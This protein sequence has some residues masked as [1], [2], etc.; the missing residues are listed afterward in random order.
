MDERAQAAKIADRLL[1]GPYAD[2]DGD[3]CVLARQ[4]NRQG[5]ELASA[6]RLL[7]ILRAYSWTPGNMDDPAREDELYPAE[8]RGRTKRG[9]LWQQIDILLKNHPYRPPHSA[10]E[11]P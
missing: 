1:D 6:V 9:E 5:E 8:W 3:T 10:S 2:P 7:H 4:F 11:Q